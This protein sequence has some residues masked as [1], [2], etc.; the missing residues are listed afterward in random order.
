MVKTK[1]PNV[2]CRTVVPDHI[3][4]VWSTWVAV[5]WRLNQHS[6]DT[7]RWAR[8]QRFTVRLP[9][10][11]CRVHAEMWF[12]WRDQRGLGRWISGTVGSS[13]DSL[14]SDS[15]EKRDAELCE[16]MRLTEHICLS[17]SSR[18][19]AGDRTAHEIRSAAWPSAPC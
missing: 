16:H 8:E 13:F 12:T 11:M 18:Q 15:R 6:G 3:K 7:G 14:Y 5:T 10:G 1:V 19:C 9:D 2:Y 4:A 17:G